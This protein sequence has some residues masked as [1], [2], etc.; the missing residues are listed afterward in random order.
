VAEPVVDMAGVHKSFNIG[1]PDET[2]ILHG[3]DLRLVRERNR[4]QGTAVLF[5]THNP[6]LAARCDRTIRV[7]DG[8]L[9]LGSGAP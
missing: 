5:V 8:Q 9:D 2:E 1:R 4:E 7:V 6:D 3:I